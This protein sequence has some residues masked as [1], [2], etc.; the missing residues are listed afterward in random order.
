M[1]IGQLDWEKI[2]LDRVLK[3]LA[4][5]LSVRIKTISV[6]LINFKGILLK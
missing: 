2:D 6:N 3:H 5:M 4:T 1:V